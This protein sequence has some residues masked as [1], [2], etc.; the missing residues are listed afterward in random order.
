MIKGDRMKAN[1]RG[2]IKNN[3]YIALILILG[4]SLVGIYIA[5]SG[6]QNATQSAEIFSNLYREENK[7]MVKT[8]VEKRLGE[9]KQ[10]RQAIVQFELDAVKHEIN[11]LGYILSNSQL[12]AIKDPLERRNAAVIEYEKMVIFDDKYLFYAISSDG[13]VLR[14]GLDNTIRGI[15]M[16]DSVDINGKKFVGEILKAMDNNNGVYVDYYWPMI[17]GGEPFKKTSFSMYLPE[18]DLIIGSGIYEI[19]IEQALKERTFKRLQSFYEK[20]KNYIFIT[21]Y[22]GISK[23]SSRSEFAGRDLNNIL[24]IDG[25]KIQDLFME[26]INSEHEGYVTYTYFKKDSDIKSEKTSYVYGIDKW[27]VYIGMGFHTDELLEVSNQYDSTFKGQHYTELINVI[28]GLMLIMLIVLAL[29]RRG[30]YLQKIYLEQEETLFTQLF[31]ISDEGIV[32]IDRDGKI[33]YQ[34]DVTSKI[35][36]LSISKYLKNDKLLLPS[37]TESTYLLS[38]TSGREYY[39]EM[40]KDQ[41][42]FHGSECIIYFLKNVTEQFLLANE[43]ERMSL[44]DELTGL[45]NRRALTNYFEDRCFEPSRQMETLLTIIDLDKFKDINDCY[46]HDIGDRVIQIIGEVF[47]KRLRS[48]D[49]FYRYGGEEFVVV[50]HLI[51]IERGKELLYEIQEIFLQSVQTEL[52]F[53][54]TFSGGLVEVNWPRVDCSLQAVVKDADLLL[55]KAKANGR[56]R[57]EI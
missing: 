26:K 6:I 2:I 43:F 1:Q 16:I 41:V 34:N 11:H 3:V 22:D 13:E 12:K 50:L 36:G 8:E 57:I 39:L 18:Y 14:S 35:F 48:N 32:I 29:I 55:Y 21:S 15:N 51:D 37:V 45:S 33:L 10:E 5:H 52:G 46:G 49:V 17:K 27:N 25:R 38:N 4:F 20:N 42:Y 19:E 56:K 40:I 54:C 28:V 44:I 31:K 47:T 30:A 7:L 24:N 53:D 9:I 23:V